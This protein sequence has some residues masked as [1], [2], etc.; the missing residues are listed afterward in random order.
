MC[1]G[2]DDVAAKFLA[3][4]EVL[5]LESKFVLLGHVGA[6]KSSDLVHDMEENGFGCAVALGGVLG[7]V[8]N[9]TASDIHGAVC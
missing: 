4:A 2:R 5:A 9:V 6:S 8:T 3:F 1:D 7:R